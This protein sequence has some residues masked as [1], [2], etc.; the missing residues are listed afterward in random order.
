M[1]A[2]FAVEVTACSFVCS[3]CSH[4]CRREAEGGVSPNM[5]P[6]PPGATPPCEPGQGW[7]GIPQ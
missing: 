2:W 7:D 6:T 4:G 5:P 3:H 1:W